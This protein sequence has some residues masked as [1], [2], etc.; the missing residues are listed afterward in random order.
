MIRR[1]FQLNP[2]LHILLQHLS[3]RRWMESSLNHGN[4]KIA[5]H[6]QWRPTSASPSSYSPLTTIRFFK[7]YHQI[8]PILEPEYGFKDYLAHSPLLFWT[9]IITGSRRYSLDPTL[10]EVLA[11][12]VA[13]LAALAIFRIS[14]YI[15]TISALLILC[16]WPLPMENASD[17]PSPVYSGVI[18]QLALQNG[19]HMR[20]ARQDFSQNH[21]S[22]DTTTQEI[23]RIRLWGW[24]KVICRWSV[25]N[26]DK[27]TII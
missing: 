11:P 7:H 19:L 24:C 3:I 4:S 26:F 20:S 5:F 2:R 13:N 15:P 16:A 25:R 10:L 17:D 6:C 9:I 14:E 21:L 27:R 23:F 18:M 1:P 8:L 12:K 22:S